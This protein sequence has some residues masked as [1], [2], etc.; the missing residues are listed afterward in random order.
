MKPIVKIFICLLILPDLVTA[1]DDTTA[2]P[3]WRPLYHFTPLKNWTNDPNGLIYLDGSYHLY[4][5]QNPFENHWGHMSWGHASSTDLVH[6]KHLPLAMPEGLDQDT[7]LR[8]SGCAVWDKYNSSGLC[9]TGGCI[10]AIYTAD[11]P[12]LKK[13]SQWIAYSNDGGMSFTQYEKNPVI[14]LHKKDFRDP[15]VSWN[16]QLNKW[17]M[18]VALPAEHAV[19]FYSSK[20]LKDWELLSSF[21]PQGY[22]SAYW[23]CPS[24]MELPVEGQPARKRWVLSVSAAGA[25]R[26]VFMQY[27]TGTF[28]GKNFKSDNADG[29][30]LPLDEGD[31]FYAAIPWNGAPGG[32]NPFIGW[33][34]PAPQ[35][36][37]PWRGQMSIPRDLS[38]R[39]TKTGLRLV[40]KPA[41]LTAAK[42]QQL[43]GG[44]TKVFT[45]I[46]ISNTDTILVMPS[47]SPGNAYWIEAWLSVQPGAD[48]GFIIAQKKDPLH[49]TIAATSVGFNTAANNFYI[50]KTLSGNAKLDAA[51]LLLTAA[52]TNVSNRIHVQVLFDRSSL[53][54]FFN[55]GEKV[56]TTQIFPDKDA[57]GLSLFAREGGLTIQSM[58]IWDL[59]HIN[60]N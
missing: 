59:S 35:P 43:S 39:Q 25:E 24:L 6:W 38:L 1:Q 57:N 2:T 5:Q 37:Y 46:H 44:R 29:T 8:F 3:Q 51:H 52:A 36:T 41:A 12:G 40:Q 4:N 16:E 55:D 27:F 49:K 31:C 54:V 17:L 10:V 34:T 23:E 53:E 13:E 42:L 26:G 21:G 14:D 33:L 19:Q 15:S 18:V 20:N 9:K 48:A 58:T 28:D 22:T 60:Q 30:V 11:Q 56:I 45:N 32:R 7:T 47:N 50:D